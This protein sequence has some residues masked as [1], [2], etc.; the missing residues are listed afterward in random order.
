MNYPEVNGNVY[1]WSS[2]EI[3]LGGDLYI[4]VKEIK[5]S[6]TLK[7][8]KIKGTHPVAIGRTRGE[9]DAEGSI[10]LWLAEADAFRQALGNGYLEVPFDIV[11]SYTENGKTLT[12]TIV[13]AKIAKDEGGGSQSPD[14]LSVSWDLDVMKILING[15][16]PVKKTLESLAARVPQ[17]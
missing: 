12:D 8:V 5:Y 16:E 2:V 10:S 3:K 7:G 1:D 13:G 14:G 11:V 17:T 4:G 15:L 9:Y 6:H